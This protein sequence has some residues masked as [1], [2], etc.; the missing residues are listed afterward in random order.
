MLCPS[1]SVCCFMK[2]HSHMQKKENVSHLLTC[3][4]FSYLCYLSQALKIKLF[5]CKKGT[6]EY[7]GAFFLIS[8][9]E[10][11]VSALPYKIKCVRFSNT[12]SEPYWPLQVCPSSTVEPGRASGVCWGF[13][14]SQNCWA[15]LNP[16][17]SSLQAWHMPALPTSQVYL[18]LPETNSWWST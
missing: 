9:N 8:Q 3:F 16:L 4:T 6:H 2:M 18:P 13:P 5:I 10:I 14:A 12:V 7:T 1:Y 17:S 15:T 11:S